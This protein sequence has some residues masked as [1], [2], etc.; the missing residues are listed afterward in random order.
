MEEDI[1]VI[2]TRASSMERV[3]TST[4]REKK[5]M[6]SGSMERESDGLKTEYHTIRIASCEAECFPID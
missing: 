6:E 2:G 1:L 4:P 5:S 3:S